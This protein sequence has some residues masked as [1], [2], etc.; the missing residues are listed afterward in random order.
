MS[1]VQAPAV[2]PGTLTIGATAALMNFS[3]QCTAATLVPSVDKGD[4]INV[5]SGAQAPGERTETFA[6][7]VTLQGDFGVLNSTTEWLYEHRGEE[8]PFTYIPNVALARKI[9][10]T[11]VVE[12]ID[13][14]GEVKTKPANDV[15]FDLIGE[16]VFASV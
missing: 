1:T 3:N 15:E 8:H 7:K 9:S 6:L 10:G 14:G 13:I 5:L 4:P 12:P 2:G 11:L 16:P